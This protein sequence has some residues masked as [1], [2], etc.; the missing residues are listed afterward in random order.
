MNRTFQGIIVLA[1]LLGGTQWSRAEILE[2][3]FSGPASG[4][5]FNGGPLETVDLTVDL[6]ANTANLQLG[7]GFAGSDVYPDLTQFFPARTWVSPT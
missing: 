7:T 6:F 2:L 3:Q 5:S 1:A 4:V